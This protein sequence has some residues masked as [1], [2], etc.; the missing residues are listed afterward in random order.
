VTSPSAS[1]TTLNVDGDRVAAAISAAL[2]AD[3][4][5][6]LSDVPGFL[7]HFPDESSLIDY[8]PLSRAQMFLER[9]A[10]GQMKRKMPGAIEALQEGVR[11]V[12]IADGRVQRPLEQALAGAGTAIGAPLEGGSLV[13]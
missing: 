11:R 7:S 2:K 13:Q 10:E 1:W 3:T 8:I 9:Y 4:L 12:V 6:I 5:I